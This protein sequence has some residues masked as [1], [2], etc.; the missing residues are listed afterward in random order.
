MSS[1][2][3]GEESAFRVWPDGTVQAVEDGAAYSHMS[4]DYAIV[5]ATSEE[6]ACER[7]LGPAPLRCMVCGAT[8]GVARDTWVG[9]CCRRITCR[10]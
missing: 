10:D 6:A 9:W 8:K 3:Q 2:A 5:L 4:D 1:A 7:V